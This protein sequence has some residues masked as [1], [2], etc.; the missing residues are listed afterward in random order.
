MSN[1]RIDDML[2][3]HYARNGEDEAPSAR[4]MAKLKTLPPQKHA[5]WARFPGILL[6]WQFAPAWPRMAALASCAA[7]GFAIGATSLD[8][9]LPF[10]VASG[11]TD[12]AAAVFEPEPLTGLR[13]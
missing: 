11:N 12:L 2:A 6:D 7:L 13:P 10:T 1:D 9:I 5:L 8:R 3:R 4:V